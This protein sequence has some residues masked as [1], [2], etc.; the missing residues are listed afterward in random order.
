[1]RKPAPARVLYRDDVL[2]SYRFHMMTASFC[3][4]LFEGTLYVDK[5][6][7]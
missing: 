1:M 7:V 4:S 6:R 5:M 3:I 2:I